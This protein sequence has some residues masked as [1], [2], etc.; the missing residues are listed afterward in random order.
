[1]PDAETTGH[2]LAGAGT[3]IGLSR[4]LHVVGMDEVEETAMLHFPDVTAERALQRLRGEKDFGM[5]VDENDDVRGF[6]GHQPVHRLRL[7]AGSSALTC[8]VTS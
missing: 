1:M 5:L 8:L 6:L 3:L 4:F 7:L 2:G